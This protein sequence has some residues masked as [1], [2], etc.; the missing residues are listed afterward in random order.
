MHPTAELRGT[1][2]DRLKGKKIVLGITGSI[3]AVECVKLAREL[4]RNGADVHTVMSPEGSKIIGPYS[5]EFATGNPVITELTGAVEHV[6]LCG[7][8]EGRADLYLISPCTANTLGKIV[9][10]VDD[11]PVTTFAT[12]A[13]GTG[14]PVILVPAMHNTMYLH[15]IVQVNLDAARNMGLEI[16]DPLFEEKKAKMAPVKEIVDRCI[17]GLSGGEMKG[18]KILVVTGATREYIDDMRFITNRATGRTGTAI[19][20]EAYYHGADVRILAGENVRD[21]PVYLDSVS[22]SDTSDLI[23]KIELLQNEWGVPDAAYFAAGISD[24]TLEKRE[25]KISSQKGGLTLDLVPTPKVISRFR[26]LYPESRLIGYKAESVGNRK[27]LIKRAY[28]RLKEVSMDL[29]VAN[30]L[31][32]VSEDRNRVMV[33]TPSK[34]AFEL[35]G[36]KDLIARFIV[37]KTIELLHDAR[38][39]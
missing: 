11:T 21:I 20:L 8:V 38:G 27:E 39:K 18:R 17:R 3:A 2:S 24:F 12:T 28:K 19:G 4:I 25:G 14:I 34:E 6:S 22:F 31:K 32:D 35:E 23:G 9:T 13:I 36:R 5:M 33:I 10:A 29:I 1:R 37:E 15:P 7:D 16:I 30:D 26:K